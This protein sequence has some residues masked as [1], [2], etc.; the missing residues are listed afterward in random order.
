MLQLQRRSTTTTAT[1][2]S[3]WTYYHGPSCA[4]RY[5]HSTGVS[6][7]GWGKAKKTFFYLKAF[8]QSACLHMFR[9]VVNPIWASNIPIPCN[10][11]LWSLHR[12]ESQQGVTDSSRL[13]IAFFH[14]VRLQD[15]AGWKQW[16]NTT[17]N[18]CRN[19]LHVRYEVNSH[20]GS[21]ANSGYWKQKLRKNP[22]VPSPAVI[23]A[24]IPTAGFHYPAESREESLDL[25]TTQP[26][27]SYHAVVDRYWKWETSNRP[28]ALVIRTWCV[29][30]ACK[31]GN[32]LDK[33]QD[34]TALVK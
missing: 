20:L 9:H 4:H 16:C 27:F 5:M 29:W 13:L 32:N 30:G 15:V 6:Q 11:Q 34:R 25:Q 31:L 23:E 22:K 2:T 18:I 28:S 17:K 10:T 12:A 3:T 33:F 24:Q 7:G 14:S 1:S 21:D 19:V 8:Q 26:R